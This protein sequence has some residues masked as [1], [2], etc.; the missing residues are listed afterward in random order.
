MTR[1]VRCQSQKAKGPLQNTSCN[2][3]PNRA[4][5]NLSASGSGG[6]HLLDVAVRPFI[7]FIHWLWLCFHLLRPF[8]GCGCAFIYCVY[9]LV[10]AV[11]SFIL[12]IY[13]LWLCA[14]AQEE[15]KA[16]NL[17]QLV[18]GHLRG[19]ARVHLSG[20]S[21]PLPPCLCTCCHPECRTMTLAAQGLVSKAK[22]S[23]A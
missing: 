2:K 14:C 13:W 16:D 15:H 17:R 19:R 1:L 6:V 20:Q 10:V 8:I 18:R 23:V 21:S 5:W 22:A 12:S 7:A 4:P 11:R 9:L 3:A